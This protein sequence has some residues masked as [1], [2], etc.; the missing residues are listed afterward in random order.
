VVEEKISTEDEVK[1][2]SKY[3]EEADSTAVCLQIIDE[4]SG[5]R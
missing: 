4:D 3:V 1:Q 5:N 2:V